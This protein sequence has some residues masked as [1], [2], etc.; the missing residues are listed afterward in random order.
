M[1]DGEPVALSVFNHGE[2]RPDGNYS[3]VDLVHV[4]FASGAWSADAQGIPPLPKQAAWPY[5][6]PETSD[7]FSSHISGVM[8]LSNGRFLLCKGADGRVFQEN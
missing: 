5:T 7:F 4:P 3:S 2:S 6:A 8:P 1:R